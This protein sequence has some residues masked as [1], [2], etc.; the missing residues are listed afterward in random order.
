MAK[1]ADSYYFDT[2]S[3]CADDACRAAHLLQAVMQDFHP[4]DVFSMNGHVW[5]CL[6]V[7]EDG[8][9]VI[10]HST[11]SDSR[12][13]Q[14]GGGVQIS[15]VGESEDCQAV[16][17]AQKYMSEYFPAWS[18]RYDAAFKS[19]SSYTSFTGTSAGK[20]SPDAPVTRAQAV[21]F[22]WRELA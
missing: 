15:G 13:G 12:T 21:T 3:S 22:L 8:S 6:G 14:P 1:V 17:L 11:P 19:Y 4:G 5:I 7:C 10:L 18:Q 20:F 16:A 9:L 2:F